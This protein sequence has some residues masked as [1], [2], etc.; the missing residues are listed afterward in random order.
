[1]Q[2]DRNAVCVQPWWR[3]LFWDCSK[4]SMRQPTA[5]VV[6]ALN[7]VASRLPCFRLCRIT[8]QSELKT[9]AKHSGFV[10]ALFLRSLTAP[11]S[12]GY[13]LLCSDVLLIWHWPVDLTAKA[14]L[15]AKISFGLSSVCKINLIL[16]F[17][18]ISVAV[19]YKVHHR[20]Q[21]HCNCFLM[22]VF[23]RTHKV[24]QREQAKKVVVRLVS[25]CYALWLQ[26]SGTYW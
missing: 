6:A 18:L 14:A 23:E 5:F 13:T 1:M 19:R 7:Q 10:S 2:L 22:S 15:E 8:L 24:H 4:M 25:V 11:C 12:W 3:N 16:G 17:A 20:C 21:C 26:W 9:V